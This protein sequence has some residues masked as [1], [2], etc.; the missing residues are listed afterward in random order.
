MRCLRACPAH[1]GGCWSAC[2]PSRWCSWCWPPPMPTAA[3]SLPTSRCWHPLRSASLCS[4]ATWWPFPWTAA[5]ST[6]RDPSGLPSSAAPGR[7][8]GCSGWAP[9]AVVLWQHWFM[10]SASA[11]PAARSWRQ[12]RS[13]AAT[14]SACPTTPGCRAP[15]RWATTTRRRALPPPPPNGRHARAPPGSRTPLLLLQAFTTMIITTAHDFSAGNGPLGT[16]R[17]CSLGH[18]RSSSPDLQ[19]E[20]WGILGITWVQRPTGLYHRPSSQQWLA[21]SKSLARAA[22]HVQSERECRDVIENTL[23]MHE[24]A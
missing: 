14:W 11:R 17:D 4:F 5:P 20:I 6:L 8:C 13:A 18:T 7:T 9:S 1:R 15:S 19:S 10:S 2:S 22:T 23:H 24:Y 12:G 16:E 21:G 3:S